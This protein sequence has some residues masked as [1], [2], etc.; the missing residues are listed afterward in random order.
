MLLIPK[1]YQVQLHPQPANNEGLRIQ[2]PRMLGRYP[3]LAELLLARLVQIWIRLHHFNECAGILQCTHCPSV[4]ERIKMVAINAAASATTA[5]HVTRNR[6]LVY[7]RRA[8]WD[9]PGGCLHS[10]RVHHRFQPVSVLLQSPLFVRHLPH[11]C[12]ELLDLRMHA[13]IDGPLICTK[14]HCL[15]ERGLEAPIRSCCCPLPPTCTL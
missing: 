7:L 1:R 10:S 6:P 9:G 13:D 4:N 2:G 12:I 14:S 8:C 3:V 11:F 15:L 5:C